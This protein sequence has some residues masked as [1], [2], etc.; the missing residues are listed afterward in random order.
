LQPHLDRP[1]FQRWLQEKYGI[2]YVL[3]R[4]EGHSNPV[5]F[6][7]GGEA[8]HTLVVGSTGY[9]K[10]YWLRTLV[11]QLVAQPGSVVVLDPKTSL[12]DQLL[13]DLAADH[14]PSQQLVL[15]DPRRAGPT[16]PI[17]AWNPLTIPDPEQASQVVGELTTLIKH[18]SPGG[19]WGPRLEDTLVHALYFLGQQGL[20]FFELPA[21]LLDDG[22]RERLLDRPREPSLL[23][24]LTAA[25]VQHFWRREY[26]RYQSGKQVDL[27]NPILN[28]T[29]PLTEVPFLRALFCQTQ[30]RLDF[31]ALFT[32]KQVWLVNLNI[33]ALGEPTKLLASLLLAKIFQEARARSTGDPPPLTLIID[34]L[35]LFLDFTGESVREVLSTARGSNMRLVVATQYIGQM[36]EA[37]RDSILSQTE[38]QIFFNLGYRD[39]QAVVPTLEGEMENRLRFLELARTE[40]ADL[41]TQRLRLVSPGGRPLRLNWA[42]L[43]RWF[44]RWGWEEQAEAAWARETMELPATALPDLARAMQIEGLYVEEEPGRYVP[45]AV[46]GPEEGTRVVL[47]P[48]GAFLEVIFPAARVVKKEAWTQGDRQRAAVHQLSHLPRREALVRIKGAETVRLRTLPVQEPEVAPEAVESLVEASLR[49]IG[50]PRSEIDAELEARRRTLQ[51]EGESP[52]PRKKTRISRPARPKERSDEPYIPPAPGSTPERE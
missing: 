26:A 6:D 18:S 35:S 2:S 39:A 50:R 45:A 44:F 12:I 10:S 28:K 15:L 52:T 4:P 21:L 20:S 42:G 23:D 34:E 46:Y 5:E 47:D 37:V 49:R 9:G 1:Y 38:L 16:H 13:V 3:E 27:A 40:P 22:F 33:S 8:Y 41:V 48:E 30:N 25:Q 43:F 14:F 51:G 29:R 11:R 7:S 36:P 19:S 17:P 32:E 31:S 24:P